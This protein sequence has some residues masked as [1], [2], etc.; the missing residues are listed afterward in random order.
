[1]EQLE[2][3]SKREDLQYALS[4]TMFELRKICRNNLRGLIW[5]TNRT[6]IVSIGNQGRLR[7]PFFCAPTL[8]HI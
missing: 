6:W 8:S 1:M 5:N 3:F 7:P 2:L 4:L